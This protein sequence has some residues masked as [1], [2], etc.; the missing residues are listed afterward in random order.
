MTL[1]L[2]R[3]RRAFR[4]LTL[5]LLSVLSFAAAVLPLRVAAQ[6]TL[7]PGLA[8]LSFEPN[9]PGPPRP[10]NLASGKNSDLQVFRAGGAPHI[11]MQEG[12][13]Y[14]VLDITNPVNPTALVYVNMAFSGEMPSVGDG[15]SYIA[16][17]GISPDGQRMA[18]G[19]NGNA[20]PGYGSVAATASGNGFNRISAGFLPRGA[21][22]T[23]VQGVASRYLAYSLLPSSGIAPGALS[24]VD[25][26]NI[27]GPLAPANLNPEQVG[28]GGRYL[29]LAGNNVLYLN[30]DT[31]RIYD[32]SSPG[33]VGNI[34]GNFALTT[35]GSGDFS[36]NRT[37]TSFSAAMDPSDA[38]KLWVLVELTNPLGYA[39]VSVKS[40]VKTLNAQ[41]F[42]VP[43]AGGSWIAGGVSALIPNG[44]GLFALMW[45]KQFGSPVVYRLFSTSVQG[46]GTA[47]GQID[48]DSNTYPTFAL[49]NSMRGLAGAGTS[50]YA[51]VPTGNSAYM[52]PLSCISPN[53]PANASMAVTNQA[54]A[55]LAD[56]ATVF[57]GDQITIVP[58]INPPTNVQALTGFGWNFDFDFHAGAAYDDNGAVASPRIK[59]PD[60]LALGSPLL[61]PPLI[62]VVGPCDPQVGGTSPGS[63]TGCW[64]SVKNNAAFA[65]GAAD[66]TGAEPIG[67][68]KAL[69]FAFEANNSLGSAGA[70]TFTLNWKVP[71]VRLA[72][73][74]ILTGAALTA[75][76]D[77]HPSATGYK[78]YFGD[79]PTALTLAPS[80][81]NAS[82][83]PTLQTS[84]QHYYWLT[85]PYSQIGYATADYAGA[86]ALGTYTVTDF[87]PAFTVNG[88][89]AGPVSTVVGQ[90][91]TVLNSSQRGA[92]VNAAG[93]YY[94]SLCAIPCSA[95]SYVLWGTMGDAPPSGAP[96]TSATIP[97][98]GVGSW[99]LKIRANYV[100]PVGTAYWPD[101][102]GAI[103]IIVNVSNCANP[104]FH[105]TVGGAASY[106]SGGFSVQAGQAVT[107]V[108]NNAY[109]PNFSWNFGDGSALD[110]TQN[111]SHTYN[112]A[113]NYTVTFTAANGGCSV[114]YPIAVAGLNPLSVVA[115]V[116]PNPQTVNVG[117]TFSCAA[118]GGAGGYTY[119]W[120]GAF[121]SNQQ[122]TF[123]TF[124]TANSYSVTCTARDA[125]NATAGAFVPFTVQASGGG[126]CTNADFHL[127]D[128]SYANPGF[129][130]AT[131]TPVTFVPN[132][133]YSSYAWSFGDG[134]S[135]SAQSPTHT[136]TNAGTYTVSL[137]ANGNCT[138]SYQMVV[139]G[140]GGSGPGATCTTVDFSIRDAATS[141]AACGV[142]G[143]AGCSGS[144]GQPLSFIPSVSMT[145]PVTSWNFGDG[146]ANTSTNPG[147]HTYL[148]GGT[149]NVVL[150]A[151]TCT[152]TYEITILGPSA[153]SGAFIAKYADLSP[154][155][156]AQV[157]SGKAM[158]FLA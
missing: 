74:Q 114:S 11:L 93:G 133:A 86:A 98:P 6:C 118:S 121:S 84:G 122:S 125:N 29:T 14:S 48:L 155:D 101:P 139:T 106:P 107:F 8:P 64:S 70:S 124:P 56:G 28:P 138:R 135:D 110:T 58:S 51:Y 41:T 151:G 69:M 153:L 99:L 87:A 3:S 60:N 148:N 120:S 26:T 4:R 38:T 50:L 9:P 140:P 17:I 39:L 158:T 72:T 10:G 100:N 2:V 145:L 96:P 112:S 147:T 65:G 92:T 5:P 144:T 127:S 27:P 53:A 108:P 36:G 134:G 102:A 88:T 78:W 91:L 95:D 85:V 137:T 77:G 150:T 34:A 25:V 152:K 32:A 97:N 66:F 119:T 61:P 55:S 44:N 20:D 1:H 109:P 62:T 35:I 18:L 45:A 132:N 123:Q 80:C 113:G 157:A 46:W 90:A 12:F 75:A 142:G 156:K 71:Q 59:A 154:F 63:G 22:G 37:P 21:V 57:L 76:P 141:L 130:V 47:P 42:Q 94:Y 52:L 126:G 83:V 105:I 146:S 111:P 103:G 40:G 67:A 31:I 23:I 19:L 128:G 7:Q 54:G 24:V 117:A 104:D 15:Q 115:S 13:G 30:Q 68:T 116:N 82:C 33:P 89:T 79:A 16:S 136:Y 143:F 149:Y 129:S 49:N 131:G 73:T 43:Q 81:T